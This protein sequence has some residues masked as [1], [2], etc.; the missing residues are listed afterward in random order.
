MRNFESIAAI[1]DTVVAQDF[2][3]VPRPL[4]PD[5]I[6]AT[7]RTASDATANFGDGVNGIVRESLVFP[8]TGVL[9]G[10]LQAPFLLTAVA[11]VHVL[12]HSSNFQ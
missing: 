3:L 9:G 11:T 12:V 4:P 7:G 8:T 5:Q 2:Q 10:N 6:E 1:L